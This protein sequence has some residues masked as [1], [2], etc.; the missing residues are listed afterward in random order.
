MA[1]SPQNN[2][3]VPG[4]PYSYDLKWMVQRLK[5]N[6]ATAQ[7]AV[8]MT[9]AAETG[10]QAV[11]TVSEMTDPDKIYIY[12]GSEAGY[13][14]GH[15][16]YYDTDLAAWTDGGT[17]GGSTVNTDFYEG[18]YISGTGTSGAVSV[19]SYSVTK[20]G[21]YLITASGYQTTANYSSAQE[22]DM[23]SQLTIAHVRSGVD[24]STY[25][26]DGSLLQGGDR[27]CCAMFS[28]EIGDVIDFRWRQQ[29]GSSGV[30]LAEETFYIKHAVI[31]LI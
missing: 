7:K 29:A 8:D 30:T 9:K 6:E 10:A 25:I 13:T 23:V 21:V 19:D 26:D 18:G 3:Y 15:W 5:E 22:A 31:K 24:L 27:C 14:A 17:Y 1:Y 2:P 12:V 20:S 11:K 28:G 4:D 16:Y